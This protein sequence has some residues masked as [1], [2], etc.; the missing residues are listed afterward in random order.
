MPAG[1]AVEL[2][3]D[4][5]YVLKGLTEWRAGWERK[6]LRNSKGEPVANLALW[7]RLFALADARR[8]TR[9]LGASGHNGDRCNEKADA[10]ANKALA[11]QTRQRRLSGAAAA[12]GAAARL[13][14]AA[15][16]LEQLEAR[17]GEVG[18]VLLEQRDE[19]QVGVTLQGA[20][21]H[22]A[23]AGGRDQL[24]DRIAR[25]PCCAPRRDGRA[26]PARAAA[27]ASSMS[28]ECSVACLVRHDEAGAGVDQ[29]AAE[30]AVEL[31]QAGQRLAAA[32]GV[33][34]AAR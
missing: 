20:D 10:L 23:R 11:L 22:V 34:H 18:A 19:E 6:G 8:V 13:G 2:V 3:S 17:Q 15:L 14:Q 33:E 16:D 29:G 24:V 28:I 1:A 21:Q 5:Q 26:A 4:S 25:A 9:A 7:K 27:A 12:S 30:Q 32:R 31:E